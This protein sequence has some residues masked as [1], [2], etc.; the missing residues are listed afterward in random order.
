MVFRI[1]DTRSSLAVTHGDYPVVLKQGLKVA[2]KVQNFEQRSCGLS[3]SNSASPLP[4]FTYH[5]I[6][7]DT[8]NMSLYPANSSLVVTYVAHKKVVLVNFCDAFTR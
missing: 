6:V 2:K 7:T 3:C 4:A 1:P 5:A 8:R